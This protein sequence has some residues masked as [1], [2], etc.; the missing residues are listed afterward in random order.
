MAMRET[1]AVRI[2]LRLLAIT[3]TNRCQSGPP[4]GTRGAAEML[5][6]HRINKRHFVYPTALLYAVAVGI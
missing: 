4:S 5:A 1:V 6:D 2:W 3:S